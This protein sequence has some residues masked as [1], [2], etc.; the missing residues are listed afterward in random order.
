METPRQSFIRILDY[1]RPERMFNWNRPFGF[2]AGVSGT[3]FWHQTIERW[4]TEGLPKDVNTP[5]KINDYFGADRSLRVILHVGVWPHYEKQVIEE[6]GQFETFYDVD[7]SLVRQ[8]KG[9]K[10]ESAMPEHLQYA[11]TN[12]QDWEV[13]ISE[14][15]DPKAP[16]RDHFEIQLDGNVIIQSAPGA[17]NF[18]QAQALI[19]DSKWPVE[20]TVGSLFGYVRNWLG[21]TN[22]AYLLYDNEDLVSEMMTHLAELSVSVLSRFL[23]NSGARIDY[24]TWWEDM[25]FNK[26]P[27][28]HPKFIERLMV[29]NYQRVNQMLRSYGIKFIGVDSDGEL[30]RLIPLWLE[31]GINFVYPNEVAANNDVVATRRKYGS[32]IRLIGGI[33][34]RA[35]SQDKATI[36]AELDRRLP[37]IQDGGYL[38]SVDHSVP[39]DI[40]FQN[41]QHYLDLYR[42]GCER[43]LG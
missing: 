1:E 17:E 37:L 28:I 27:L 22:L 21:L 31:G 29:S 34:K 3:Q 15:L 43:Y 24:A 42:S 23:E 40:P 20:I 32:A 26:G 25:A 13:F 9:A 12:R 5:T 36:K 6:N 4:H 8:Y 30:D 14:R 19:H 38:P 35:L 41:Y 39:P 16:G 11:V 2:Y 10:Y 18:H 33:D 7:G